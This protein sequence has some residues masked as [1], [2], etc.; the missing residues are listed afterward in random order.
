MII[1]NRLKNDTDKVSKV[2][3]YDT[4]GK[5]LLLKRTDGK[6]D[7]DLPGGHLKGEENHKEGA[8]REV[9]EETG[10]SVTNIKPVN[11]NDNTHFFKCKRPEGN[12]SLQPKEHTDFKWVNPKD[13]DDYKIRKSLKKAIEEAV[14]IVSEDFQQDVKRKHRKMKIRLIGKGK[15]KYN[16]GG[17]MKKPPYKRSKSSPV[18][19]G[20]S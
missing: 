11:K 15:N 10:L 5:V 6:N 19:F 8:E 17:K 3:I 4:D 2:I 7:W 20:G 9:K 1:E 12:I 13:I 18:G 14:K 16:V